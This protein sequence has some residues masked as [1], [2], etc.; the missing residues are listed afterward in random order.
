[1]GRITAVCISEKKGTVKKDIGRCLVIKGYGLAHDA[2]AGSE[3]QVSLLPSESVERFRERT[4]GKVS[5]PAGVFGE[6][7]LT[8][9]IDYEKCHVGTRLRCGEVL[10]E[11]TQIGKKCHTDCE[12]RRIAGDCIMPGEGVFAKVLEG[13][14]ISVGDSAGIA[15]SRPFSVCVLTVSDRAFH[16]GYADESGAVTADVCRESG[17]E[18]TETALCDDDENNV[19][20]ELLR[21][22]ELSPDLILTTGGTGFSMRDR[23]PE[24][25]L[26]IADRN[27]SGIAE[28]IR[29]YSMGIT[30]KAMLSR[31]VSVIRGRTLIVNMPGSPR[32]VRE[33]AEYIL[34]HIRHG[35]ELLRGE[36]DK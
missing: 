26:R 24:A 21:L 25:T 33:C 18:V 11:I 14:Y 22:C 29:S 5:L 30:P 17:F 9:G 10:L 6:N 1:M 16:G 20:K 34:P 15:V 7:I 35:I 2:H 8:E 31:A 23:V 32:A 19:E 28:A 4:D 13:G 3:R 12:I 36:A 27:A